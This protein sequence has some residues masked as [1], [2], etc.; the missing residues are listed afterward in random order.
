V[1]RRSQNY[2]PVDVEQEALLQQASSGPTLYDTAAEAC[3]ACNDSHTLKAQ[4]DATCSGFQP[5]EGSGKFSWHLF[6]AQASTS[7]SEKFDVCVCVINDQANH[8]KTSCNG[9]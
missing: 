9:L 8:G 3:D 6:D 5:A 7:V 2:A 4:P 1:L